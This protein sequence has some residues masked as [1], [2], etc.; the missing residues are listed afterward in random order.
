MT[1]GGASSIAV[2]SGSAGSVRL[3]GVVVGVACRDAKLF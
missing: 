1:V 2:I 3:R